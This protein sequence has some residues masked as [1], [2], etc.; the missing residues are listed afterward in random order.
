[1]SGNRPYNYRWLHRIPVLVTGMLL[2]CLFFP[3]SATALDDRILVLPPA[4]DTR[5]SAPPSPWEHVLSV[6]E[7][8]L[9]E[10]E[11]IPI[12]AVVDAWQGDTLRLELWA[13]DEAM[14]W[15]QELDADWVLL[16]AGKAGQIE[17][18]AVDPWEGEVRGPETA[19]T[20]DEC[21]LQLF[22][23]SFIHG[24]YPPPP[25]HAYAPPV[26]AGGKQALHDYLHAHDL[27]PPDATI[28][29]VS[30]NA[31]VKV[32]LNEDG[33]P[34]KVEIHYVSETAW[35]FERVIEQALWAIEWR[36][37][38]FDGKTV[39]AVFRGSM[40]ANYIP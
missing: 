27:Y 10:T 8:V 5:F 35:H 29:A 1:M 12:G 13:V 22:P 36:A 28:Q 20:V 34:L 23:A 3:R 38:I 31:D 25:G 15:G 9:N 32:L 40:S 26:P 39:T 19:G 16:A 37:G 7:A 30:V 18:Q 6:T 4:P 21:L 17:M 11:L 2:A 14:T 24:V 33:V